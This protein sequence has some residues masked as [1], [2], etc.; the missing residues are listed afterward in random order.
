MVGDEGSPELDLEGGE[1][2]DTV[3]AVT[4]TSLTL[5]DVSS[6]VL[7]VVGLRV[8]SAGLWVLPGCSSS[9]E[10]L[11]VRPEGWWVSIFGDVQ[12]SLG[13][14]LSTLSWLEKL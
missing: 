1:Q 3:Q 11:Q 8:F 13:E 4:R 9:L 5:G 14:V 2:Q 7:S 10:D 6:L 12:P